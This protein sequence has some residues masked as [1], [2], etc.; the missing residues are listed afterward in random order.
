MTDWRTVEWLE[1]DGRGGFAM[2][3]VHGHLSRRYHALVL[4]ALTPPTGRVVLVNGL[5]SWIELP[6]GRTLPLAPHVFAESGETDTC[7]RQITA[8]QHDPWPQ[9]T[10]E[11]PGGITVTHELFWSRQ[12]DCL[13]LRWKIGGVPQGSQLRLRPLVSGRDYHS[14]QTAGPR[15]RCAVTN[16]NGWTVLQPDPHLPRVGMLGTFQFEHDPVWRRGLLYEVERQRG[17]VHIEDLESP[18][19]LTQTL[20]SDT[21]EAILILAPRTEGRRLPISNDGLS[22]FHECCSREHHRRAAFPSPLDLAADAYIVSRG[23]GKTI[24]AGYPWFTDWGR[25]TFIAMR[26]LCLATGRLHD[27]QSILLEWAK[28]VSRGMVPNRFTDAGDAP[29]FNAVDASLW[30]IVAVHDF[31]KA[32]ENAGFA[33]PDSHR[34][35]LGAAVTEILAGYSAGTRHRIRCDDDG[36]LAAGEPG[37]QLTWMDAKVNDWVVTPRIGKPVEIQALWYNALRIGSLFDRRWSAAAETVRR[38]FEARFWNAGRGCLFDV[39]DVDDVPGRTDGSIRPNQVFAV[40]GL[41]FPL[42]EGERARLVVDV[43]EKHLVTPI[44]LR[45]LAPCEPAYRGTFGCTILERDGAYHQGMVW[46]WLMGP[47]VEAWVRVRGATPGVKAEARQRF[48]V[49]L[50]KHLKEAGM[51]HVSEVADGDPPHTPAG[52]PFQAWS[53][54]EL[55]RLDR[56]VLAC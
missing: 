48:I 47:F 44:G 7:G 31:L 50:Q 45:S 29:E 33:V 23:H 43:A 21:R 16:E 52:C 20:G 27:A 2:G 49:P 14:V 17:L 18:G 9:W 6:D 26:G 8:F 40:G 1:A 34:A 12:E 22:L 10:L 15:F 51:G 35:Q 24:V 32:C 3:T 25:D 54:G 13:C 55:L 19:I 53:V 46:C 39:V 37:V 28:T 5:E 41:P 56:F 38:S 11:F 42:L 30:F 36:L 4:T